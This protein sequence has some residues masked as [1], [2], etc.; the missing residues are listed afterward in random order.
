[1]SV[2][3]RWP[4]WLLMAVVLAAF[5]TIGAT[6]ASGA[7]SNADRVDA[8]AKTIKCPVC[9]S[10]SVFD[11]KAQASQ[12]I[13]D[14]IARQVAA[15]RTDG[16]IRAYVNDRFKDQGLLLVPPK[17]G[18]DSLVWV[19]PV[20]AVVLAAGGLAVAFHRWR[21][22]PDLALTEEDR[23]IVERYRREHDHE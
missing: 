17:T 10:E 3:K 11:S 14:E 13:R 18:I 1:V 20:V 21:T 6:R 7:R 23:S 8:I 15:G 5:L 4:G 19:L 12:N 16:E 22:V 2:F 9:R